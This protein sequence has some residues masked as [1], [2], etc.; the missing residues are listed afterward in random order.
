MP[1][2]SVN[3]GNKLPSYPFSPNTRS[4]RSVPFSISK[5]R[6]RPNTPRAG[7]SFIPDNTIIGLT[8]KVHTILVYR[9]VHNAARA[10]QSFLTAPNE[11]QEKEPW[12]PEAVAERVPQSRNACPTQKQRLLPRPEI[13]LR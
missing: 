9:M 13:Y 4:A 7:V 5:P 2:A 3:S 10:H 12:S 1:M 8:I 11:L 6:G